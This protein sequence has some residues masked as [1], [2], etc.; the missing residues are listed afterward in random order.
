MVFEM[1]WLSSLLF[2]CWCVTDILLAPRSVGSSFPYLVHVHRA[3]G[4]LL[5]EWMAEG[6]N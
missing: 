1:R 6:K 2:N 4:W 5:V 3:Q